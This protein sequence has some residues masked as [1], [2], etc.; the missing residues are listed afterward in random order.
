MIKQTLIIVFLMA[1]FFSVVSCNSDD[2][3]QENPY[4]IYAGD[5]SGTFSGD[6]EGTW[7]ASIDQNGYV[8]GTLVSNIATFPMSIEGQVSQNGEVDMEY[9]DVGGNQVGTM[10]GSLTAD[11]AT[12]NWSGFDMQGTWEGSKE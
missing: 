1:G 11:T 2:N 4:E 10:T 9:F 3:A 6:D 5:W 12:G 7:S 8:I